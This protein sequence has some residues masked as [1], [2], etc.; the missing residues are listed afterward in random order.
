MLGTEYAVANVAERDQT[1][2]IEVCFEVRESPFTHLQQVPPPLANDG[3]AWHA[4]GN[5]RKGLHLAVNLANCSCHT[6]TAVKLEVYFCRTKV[7]NLRISYFV[8]D[9][10]ERALQLL[11]AGWARHC[12]YRSSL[13]GIYH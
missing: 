8:H 13:C 7:V 1:R 4:M 9:M 6:R 12:T 10:K 11:P 5:A 2:G 3:E